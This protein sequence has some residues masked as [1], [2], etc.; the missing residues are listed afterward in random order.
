MRG[1][2]LKRFSYTGGTASLARACISG[3]ATCDEV[4]EEFRKLHAE[5]KDCKICKEDLCN[6]D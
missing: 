3:T 2:V 1:K 6:G 5:L 4:R